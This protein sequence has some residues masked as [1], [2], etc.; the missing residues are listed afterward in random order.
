M[1]RPARAGWGGGNARH[2]GGFGGPSTW[3]IQPGRGTVVLA[4]IML[5]LTTVHTWVPLSDPWLTVSPE[6]LPGLHLTALVTNLG[7][8]LPGS[9]LMLLIFALIAGY[10]FKERLRALWAVDRLR[11]IAVVGGVT[12]G[13]ALVN[14]LVLPGRTWGLM[15]E[16]LVLLWFGTGVERRWGRRRLFWFTVW[17]TLATNVLGALLAWAWPGGL[18]PLFGAGF[19][20]LFGSGP[21]SDALL[22]V[23]CLMMGSQRL[24]ILNIEARKLVWVLVIINLLDVLLSGVIAGL[25]GLAAIGV[26]WMLVTGQYRPQVLID[27]VRLWLIDRRLERRK[28]GMTVIEGGGRGTG[29]RKGG[30]H[31]H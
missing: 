10:I 11:L 14:E 7:V 5:A 24:A 27:R 18:G 31:L 4:S 17:V 12:I 29:R 22:T 21:L 25:M 6:T 9:P 28:A 2:G 26:T 23:W 8:A 19:M 16:A 3:S 1:V 15:G 30:R 20:P 13:L